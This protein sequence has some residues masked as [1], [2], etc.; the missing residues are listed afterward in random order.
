MKDKHHDNKRIK[1]DDL[2]KEVHFK[3]P[4]QYFDELPQMIQSR[5]IEE[6]AQKQS[7]LA[8]IFGKRSLRLAISLASFVLL[9]IAGIVFLNPSKEPTNEDCNQ[10]LA[11]VSAKEIKTYYE[12]EYET[13]EEELIEFAVD[14]F[15]NID[16]EALSGTPIKDEIIVPENENTDNL[17]EPTID[18]EIE[19]EILDEIDLEEDYNDFDLEL[20]DID[21][22]FLDE[23][24]LDDINTL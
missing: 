17:P 1:L 8:F 4:D 22:E 5:I 7:I 19:K 9:I 21:D 24:D 12:E 16:L 18:Q 15:D 14:N 23:I 10:T 6:R 13:S 2:K 3:V 20:D 11:C